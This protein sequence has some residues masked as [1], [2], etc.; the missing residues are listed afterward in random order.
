MRGC[1]LETPDLI[2]TTVLIV[3]REMGSLIKDEMA[4]VGSRKATE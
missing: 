4:A 3:R 2:S 1:T